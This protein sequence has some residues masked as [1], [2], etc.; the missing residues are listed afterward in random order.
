MR[1][2][3][4]YYRLRDCGNW[5]QDRLNDRVRETAQQPSKKPWPSSRNGGH[6]ASGCNTIH[7][8]A[9]PITSISY[10][11]QRSRDSFLVRPTAHWRRIKIRRQASTPGDSAGRATD[12]RYQRLC[13]YT[14][15]TRTQQFS[16]RYSL[17]GKTSTREDKSSKWVSSSQSSD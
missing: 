3:R 11:D 5:V 7:A 6:T 14:S 1:K 12:T 2:F 15:N 17:Y 8:T 10:Q 9:D 13:S 4:S 16:A